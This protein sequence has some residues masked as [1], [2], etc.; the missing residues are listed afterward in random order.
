MKQAAAEL[1][2]DVRTIRNYE[3]GV[4][5]I[6]YPAIRLIRM[7]AGYQLAG[8]G[9]ENWSFWQGKLWSPEGRSFEAHEL[10]YIASYI[11]IARSAIKEYEEQRAFGANPLILRT[12]FDSAEP[13][14]AAGSTI[15]REPASAA[16]AA[17]GAG[18]VH[19]TAV[20]F[21]RQ[22]VSMEKA[23]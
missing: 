4:S 9:W 8:R 2:V 10:R 19:D 11:S 7:A 16:T 3:N 6:P 12:V 13:K 1:D 20:E 22:P 17:S 15:E 18:L 21:E 14:A 23:A 5:R